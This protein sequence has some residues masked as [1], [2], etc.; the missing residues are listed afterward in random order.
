[1]NCFRIRVATLLILFIAV[2]TQSHAQT[3]EADQNMSVGSNVGV[4]ADPF[5]GQ[6]TASLPLEV[7]P[8]RHG[9]QPALL[10][11]Y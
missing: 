10:G 7:P 3:T 8:G 2:A 11:E 9:I 4:Q 5:T 6:A 1:M